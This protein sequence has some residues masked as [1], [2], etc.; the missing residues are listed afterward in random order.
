MSDAR[1]LLALL[2][3][4]C[5]LSAAAHDFW[6]QPSE[7]W[8]MPQAVTSMTL[9]VGHGSSRQRSPI[10]LHRITRF[11][12]ISPTGSVIDLRENLRVGGDAQDAEF[13]F[14]HSGAYVLVLETDD[15]A[16]SRLP[17]GPF[18]EYLKA[19]GLTPALEQRHRTHRMDEDGIESYGRRAK[20]LVQVGS[21]AGSQAQFTKPLGL[22]LEIVPEVSPYAE[23]R[24]VTF[25]VRVIYEGRPLADAL[26]KLTNLEHDAKPVETQVT[27]D[28]GRATFNMPV[29]GS[30]LL[31]VVWTKPRAD[32]QDAEFETTFSSLSFGFQSI[33]R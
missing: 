29:S 25:P 23:P 30:W 22:R 32:S 24:A 33:R 11:E 20:S 4:L 12:A 2:I 17:A 13:Q 9:Q 1:W 3:G 14:Q 28:S 31:S 19:E 10:P 18:N 16:H 7:Y 21:L 6:V 8:P 15:D 5:A 27:N 26:I